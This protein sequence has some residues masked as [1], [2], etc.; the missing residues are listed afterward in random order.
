MPRSRHGDVEQPPFLGEQLVGGGH[1]GGLGGREL[2][3]RRDLDKLVHA[4]QRTAHP[5]IR[6]AAFLHAG[7]DDD[8]PL[9]ALGPVRRQDAD[10]I[11][12]GGT[13]S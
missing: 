11:A 1:G 7:H 6:P 3:T 12:R 10:R 2:R 13:F 5:E 4:E 8:I 9:Q